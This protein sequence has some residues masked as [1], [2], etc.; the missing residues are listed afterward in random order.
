MLTSEATDIAQ[1]AEAHR[2]KEAYIRKR[3]TKKVVINLSLNIIAIR[4][5]S[6]IA[7]LVFVFK[8]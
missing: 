7:A 8:Y 3:R 5:F 1:N 6:N 2:V 4:G